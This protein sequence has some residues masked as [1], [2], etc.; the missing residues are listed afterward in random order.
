MHRIQGLLPTIALAL[1]VGCGGGGGG[2]TSSGTGSGTSTTGSDPTAE[3][4]Y[5]GTLTNST[6]P[7]F[8]LLVLDDGSYWA[9]YGQ[10]TSSAFMFAGFVQGHGTSTLGTSFTSSDARD[11][12]YSPA[13]AGNVTASFDATKGTIFGSV[14]NP[15]GSVQFDGGPLV[16]S[17]YVYKTPALLS[18]KPAAIRRRR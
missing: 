1:L 13:V 18:T 12:G 6:S 11:F 15:S 8:E 10:Q 7:N 16:G 9:L 5:G 4:V 14:S 2:S 3:G 17:S